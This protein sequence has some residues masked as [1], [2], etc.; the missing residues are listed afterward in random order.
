M[1]Y[2]EALETAFAAHRSTFEI[3][4]TQ[5]S[6][7]ALAQTTFNSPFSKRLSIKAGAAVSKSPP[8]VQNPA[9]KDSEHPA[10]E[11]ERNDES[12]NMTSAM[13]PPHLDESEGMPRP[14]AKKIDQ[15]LKA[16]GS[17]SR[18]AHQTGEATP[19]KGNGERPEQSQ[20]GAHVTGPS[21]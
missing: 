7:S 2:Q 9:P 11:E 14:V 17:G 8:S 1:D 19:E 3:S 13:S 15:L 18:K 12:Q 20:E 10:D 6:Q 16:S 4:Q 21:P 5:C